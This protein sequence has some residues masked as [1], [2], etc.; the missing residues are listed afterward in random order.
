MK[1]HI[2]EMITEFPELIPETIR[3]CPWN[4]YSYNFNAKPYCW[5]SSYKMA[6]G[7]IAN[8]SQCLFESYLWCYDTRIKSNSK[9]LTKQKV[10]TISSS[11]AELVGIDDVVSKIIVDNF[12]QEAQGYDRKEN[13][14]Y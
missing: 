1:K 3:K 12:F 6:C 8:G 7:C 9:I 10:N 14:I 4:D 5:Y 13:V 11:K 2:R